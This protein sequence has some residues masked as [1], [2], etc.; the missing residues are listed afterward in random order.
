MAWVALGAIVV[1]IGVKLPV[2]R[3]ALGEPLDAAD[4]AGGGS[5]GP[6]RRNVLIGAAAAT[7]LATVMTAGQTVPWLK[8]L[9][10]LAP[11]P[12][13]ARRVFPSIERHSLPVSL[14]PR[15][16]RITG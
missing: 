2:I 7:T 16:R 3:R 11:A 15:D 13:M 10:V 8:R 4:V 5:V 14:A 1:H 12:G 6:S 9:S